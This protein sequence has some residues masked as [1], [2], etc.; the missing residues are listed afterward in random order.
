MTG[1]AARA[2]IGQET[3]TSQDTN[4]S[5]TVVGGVSGL[6]FAGNT[7]F[8]ADSNRVGSFP[9][10]NRVLLFQN[11]SSQLPP[12][13]AELPYNS[14][15]PV[16]VGQANIVLG[17]PDF[18]TTTV[19]LTA[20]QSDLRQPTAVASDGVHL[21][22]ADT[23]HNRVLIWNT[24]PSYNNAP[25]DVVIGQPNFTSVSIPGD[26]PNASSMRGPQ[27]V[28][29]QNGKLYVAD[30]QN[31]RVLV[32][33]HIP[34]TSGVAADV[35]IGAPNFTT[36]VQTDI[37]Q[38]TTTATA[39]NLLNPVSVTSDG[40]RLYVTD[41]GFNRVLIWNSIPT[42]NGA[43]ADVV[44]GQPD[45]VSSI[46]NNAYS[47]TA[48]S[49]STDTTDKEVPVL[50]TVSNGVDP[51]GNPTYPAGCNS[52]L[53]FPRYALAGGDHLFVADGGNDR[54]LVFNQVP[55]KNAAAADEILGQI[56]GE[57]D[58][59]TDASD[60]LQTP[61]SLAWDGTNLFVSDS[62]NDRIVVY[63][64]GTNN[65]QYQAVRNAA[66]FDITAHGTIAI[67]GTIQAGDSATVTINGI[68]Y[69]YTVQAT[70][71]VAS[72]VTSITALINNA[73]NGAGD[74]NLVAVAD[75]VNN[76]VDLN[77]KTPGD[78]GNN[79]AY[80][81]LV[82]AAASTTNV[83]LTAGLA[84]TA[85]GANLAG[86]GNA[87]SVAP[88]TIVTI[89][90]TGLSSNTVSARPNA[91]P[92][93]TQLGGTEVYFDGIQAP[94][95]YVSPT[96]IN[97]QIPWEVGDSSSIN[98][99][100]RS[101]MSDGSIMVTTALATTIV[102]AN[103]G[104]FTQPGP[105]NPLVA[106]SPRLAVALHSTSYATAVVSVDGSVTAG[107]LATVTVGGRSYSYAAQSTDT[108]DTIRDNLVIQLNN[109]PQVSAQAA[110]L[111]DRI[112][113]TTRVQG[114]EGNGIPITATA[115]GGPSNS[116]L[117]LT[118]TALDA[119]TCCG[120]IAGSPITQTNPA[121]PGE[122][123][124]ILAT[125]L[126]VPVLSDLVTP[127]IQTGV[128]YP[129]GG[130]ITSPQEFVSSFVGGST[131]DV[132]QATLLPGSVGVYEV[133]LHTNSGLAS[134]P[135]SVITIAQDVYVSNQASVP[136][137]NNGSLNI[138]PVLSVSKTHTGNFTQGQQ[139]AAYTVTVSNVGSQN[140]TSGV[141]TLT[142]TLPAGET[143]VSIVGDGWSCTNNVCI[144]SDAIPSG[145]SYPTLTVTVNVASNAVSSVTNT[146][147]VTGGSSATATASDV[148]TITP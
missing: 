148:T 130:P 82:T 111:F 20:T 100:V 140:P 49:A 77:A 37:S 107:N 136:V 120:N 66:S 33:N 98:A 46:A 115:T 64:I 137:V 96:Q 18:V 27:G 30:T 4:S 138:A 79:V 10:N 73:N 74:P 94:L 144:R 102:P 59:A 78:L 45:L 53:S 123:I 56:G 6:A 108:L 21:V 71:T 90:G 19:N 83:A 113:L 104:I 13:T 75:T 117:T 141:V 103:P 61:L 1:Q 47:G 145:G 93:P 28:W 84:A 24:I 26:Q 39:S 12:P 36:F 11:L 118:M 88:G 70:D 81:V 95:L 147:T 121:L 76:V 52:T 51:A 91:N 114:P 109:D 99:Y 132:L 112:I 7:L 69:T 41:L 9:S 106:S 116:A 85:A 2:V 48:A 101:V 139:G 8:V 15:C 65:V 122:I 40:V 3:F 25:A 89:V 16:C 34:T 124:E 68:N 135:Y 44:I 22:V 50:C 97:A 143:L 119:Q 60:S 42:T 67:G 131:G 125:G 5:D 63:S 105:A 134:N 35:V 127:L 126:G 86:G 133:L 14:K 17:Q 142:D 29:I 129:V 31:N 23:D 32:Y 87:A 43:P 62:Y 110:G 146:V 55:T 128:Q 80:S 92:L 58:Q 54:V 72:I 57:V 38:Q